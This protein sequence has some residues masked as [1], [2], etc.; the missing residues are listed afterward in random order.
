M[1]RLR[2]PAPGGIPERP[3]GAD[4]KSVVTD[5]A[6]PNPA[7]PTKQKDLTFRQVFLFGERSGADQFFQSLAIGKL[8]RIRH[9]EV[10]KLAC[11]TERVRIFAFGENPA[12]FQSLRFY[13][14][15]LSTI[16][17]SCFAIH[18]PLH[19]GGYKCGALL[20]IIGAYTKRI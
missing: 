4:C 6:G 16:P 15:Y 1:V 17:P 18:L 8:V 11:Q 5:F 2:S 9:S 7:S 14:F 19:K 12:S 3:K 13:N 10:G 20:L